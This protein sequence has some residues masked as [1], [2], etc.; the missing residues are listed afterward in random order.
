MQNT[1][2]KVLVDVSVWYHPQCNFFPLNVEKMYFVYMFMIFDLL[3]CCFKHKKASFIYFFSLSFIR[4][5]KAMYFPLLQR[6][7]QLSHRAVMFIFKGFIHLSI[8][9]PFTVYAF[10]CLLF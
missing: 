4:N 2:F 7:L 6:P 9:S 8:S 5:G 3:N 1:G 10:D